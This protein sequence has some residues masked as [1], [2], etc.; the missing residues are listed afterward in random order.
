MT[1]LDSQMRIRIFRCTTLGCSNSALKI[2]QVYAETKLNTTRCHAL[3]EAPTGA[4]W[5]CSGRVLQGTL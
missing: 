4:G 5:V 3:A 1:M 2:P